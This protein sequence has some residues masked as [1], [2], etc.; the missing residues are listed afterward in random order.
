MAKMG[1]FTDILKLTRIEHSIMLVIA[2]LAAEIIVGGKL[3]SAST[4]AFSIIT[5][6][7]VSMGAFAINDYF[8][9]DVDRLNK[10]NRPL[11]TGSLSRVDALY[12]TIASMAIGAGAS[13]F[14]NIYCFAIAI[15]FA[16]ISILYS[17][18]LKETLFWGNAYV[19]IS[20]VIPF[21]YG[22]YVMS[23]TLSPAIV[24]VSAIIFASGLAREIHGTI[25]DYKGDSKA[26][27]VRSFPKT[28]GISGS[29]WL[30]LLLYLAAIALSVYL[31]INV[32]PFA[33]NIVY[34]IP[35]AVTD[36]L[37]IY[38]GIGYI[39]NPKQQF[40]DRTR[41]MSLAAMVIALIAFLLSALV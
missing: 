15:F 19:A 11:V 31:F 40:Y 3:P 33:Y 21:V 14:I 25:R 27:N 18:R 1:K 26:R 5:P 10:K 29:A 8:D 23:L 28:I 13:Y 12:V 22:N 34:A 30:S 7:F 32:R 41:N 37:L 36:L 24:I 20:M 2:V 9:V 39:T 35:V 38:V 6:I 4:L 17:Y 16:V